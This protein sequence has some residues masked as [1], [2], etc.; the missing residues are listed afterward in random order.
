MGS[1]ILSNLL[2][3]SGLNTWVTNNM[4]CLLS[5]LA[6]VAVAAAT[7]FDDCG[8]RATG[9]TV[10]LVGCDTPP[11]IFKKGSEVTMHVTMTETKASETYHNSVHAIIGGIPLPWPGFDN[12]FCGKLSQGDCP[13][14][15]GY[16]KVSLTIDWHVHDAN[17]EDA[18]CFQIPAEI[19]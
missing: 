19:V 15:A 17:E 13:V 11:C 12:D 18:V 14:D 6:L 9:V 10:D 16:P 3:S 4:K 1:L 5:I 7:P 8:S 2:T